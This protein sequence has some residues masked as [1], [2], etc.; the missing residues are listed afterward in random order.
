MN[1]LLGTSISCKKQTGTVVRRID[2]IGMSQ[3][4]KHK[5]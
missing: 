1:Y 2:R 5:A 3:N 4:I